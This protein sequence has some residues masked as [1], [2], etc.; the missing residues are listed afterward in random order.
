[1]FNRFVLE[2][3]LKE[4]REEY[5]IE[6]ERGVDMFNEFVS[7]SS[8]E[9]AYVSKY[10]NEI[11]FK[12][13]SFESVRK[14]LDKS[15]DYTLKCLLFDKFL[16]NRFTLPTIRFHEFTDILGYNNKNQVSV[17]TMPKDADLT[18]DEVELLSKGYKK[19]DK[20]N[21]FFRKSFKVSC[22][23]CEDIQSSIVFVENLTLKKSHYIQCALPIILPWFFGDKL[24]DL[25][26]ELLRTLSEDSVAHY[27]VCVDKF[28]NQYNFK[29]MM[30]KEMLSGCYERYSERAVEKKQAELSELHSHINACNEQ[31]D[32]LYKRRRDCQR[33]LLGLQSQSSYNDNELVDYFLNN[34]SI[35]L[36]TVDDEGIKFDCKSFIEYFD[37]DMAKTIINNKDSYIYKDYVGIGYN[38]DCVK[39]FMTNIFIT[40]KWKLNMFARYSIPFEGRV[41]TISYLTC[42]AGNYIPNTHIDQYNCLGDYERLINESIDRIDYI[43]AIEQC[44]ASCKS[45]DLGDSYVTGEF[46]RR[47]NNKG[48]YYFDTKCVEIE[49]GTTITINEA[50]NRIEEELNEQDN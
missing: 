10:T 7:H 25:E 32:T 3:L 15:W 24:T 6:N 43:T 11:G 35:E 13:N 31:L 2:N 1:M 29:D 41:Y 8:W 19:V 28:V 4:F 37:D 50:M 20:V 12:I 30:I 23:V 45:F 26:L 46:F 39:E 17:V 40:K 48:W 16:K 44:V 36:L 21:E 22:Y 9:F 49:D 5:V 27:L 14:N 34:N 42:D 33:L 47:I 38:K 18:N